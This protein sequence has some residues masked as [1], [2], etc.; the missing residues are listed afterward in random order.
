MGK[1][2]VTIQT[3][4]E[5]LKEEKVLSDALQKSAK[6]TTVKAVSVGSGQMHIKATYNNTVITATDSHGNVLAWSSA[7]SLGFKGPKK[8]TPYAASK[9]VEAVFEKIQKNPLKK[10]SIF[11]RG[12]GTGRE[13]AIH[14]IANQG[15][16]V[17]GLKDVTPVPHNGCRPPKVRRV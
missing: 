3:Q 14:A 10:V 8:A 2:K 13:A 16:E 4:E 12:I 17:I 1:K 5:L 6:P 11:V 15:V 9:V 7:G